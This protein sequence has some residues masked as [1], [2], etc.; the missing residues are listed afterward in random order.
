MRAYGSR[1]KGG[2]NGKSNCCV[3]AALAAVLL[4]MALLGP[5][6]GGESEAPVPIDGETAARM[7]RAVE[8]VLERDG[9]PG[10]IV[11]V[12]VSERGEWTAAVGIAD[13]GTG[14]EM[15]VTDLMRIGGVTK[16]FTATL[17]LQLVDEGMLGLEDPLAGFCP[18]VQNAREVSVRM[19]LNHTSGIVDDY[20]NPAFW[21]IASADPLYVWQ[22]E[23]L[24]KASMGRDIDAVPGEDFNYSNANYLLLGIIV[25]QVTGMKLAEAMGK[26]LFAPLGLSATVFPEGPEIAGPHAHSFISVGD[27]A[28]MYDMTSG[29][30]PS[31][32]WAAGAIVSNLEDMKVWARALA[33][34]ELLEEG[35]QDERLRWVE[36]PGMEG[37][38]AGYRYG[39]GILELGGFVGHNGEFSG[40]QASVF[41]LP[42]REA[43]I[44]VMLNSNINPT[45]SQD[46]FT[47]LAAIL[48][49]GEVPEAW[50]ESP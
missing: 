3:T 41:H 47:R 20:R 5:A 40:F 25:E 23:E 42:S 19:L 39:L 14:Q 26:Y 46:I 7:E 29:I 45:G 38:G 9:I 31:I 11:G 36:V 8:E 17:V 12:W 44:V 1:Q 22:P 37:A 30:D 43:S 50:L 28:G 21:D 18:W 13:R 32:T 33:T 27:N 16:S 15:S 4:A 35:T 48:F 10:A 24:V 6:C 34:G 49:P 2:M